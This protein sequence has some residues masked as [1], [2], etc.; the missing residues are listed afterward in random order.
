MLIGLP[1]SGISSERH[2]PVSG[3]KEKLRLPGAA[4]KY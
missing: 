1:N 4:R 2:G 3:R